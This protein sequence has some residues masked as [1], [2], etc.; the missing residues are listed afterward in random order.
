[1]REHVPGQLETG[2]DTWSSTDDVGAGSS[3]GW[4][5]RHRGD[6]SPVAEIFGQG[7]QHQVCVIFWSHVTNTVSCTAPGSTRARFSCKGSTSG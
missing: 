7:A 5:H 6:I 1:M 4:Y 3:F 2:D